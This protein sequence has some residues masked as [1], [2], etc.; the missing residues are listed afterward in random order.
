MGKINNEKTLLEKLGIDSFKD[1]TKEKAVQFALEFSKIDPKLAKK[2]LEQFPQFKELALSIINT[3]ND[4]LNNTYK[5]NKS[6]QEHFY[7]ACSS[8]IT[9]LQEEL[10]SD[11]ITSEERERIENKMIEVAQMIGTKDSENKRFLAVV[12]TIGTVVAASIGGIAAVMFGV[13]PKITL[14]K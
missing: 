6:S 14:K 3:Q 1:M 10:K 2:A 9:S 4:I 7:E 12:A 11:T 8:I 5:E 13:K